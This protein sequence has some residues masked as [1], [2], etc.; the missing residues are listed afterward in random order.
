MAP[1]PYPVMSRFVLRILFLA[2]LGLMS[3]IISLSESRLSVTEAFWDIVGE[4]LL[5]EFQPNADRQSA[6]A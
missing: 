4:G 3:Q 1:C 6:A 2:L 5:P